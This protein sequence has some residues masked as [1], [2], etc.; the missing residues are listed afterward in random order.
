[1]K[2]AVAVEGYDES[3]FSKYGK[4]L[5][6]AVKGQRKAWDALS[7]SCSSIQNDETIKHLQKTALLDR[8]LYR[9]NRMA[10]VLLWSLL[11]PSRF[12]K[13]SGK[14]NSWGIP[15]LEMEVDHVGIFRLLSSGEI[16]YEGGETRVSYRYADLL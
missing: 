2:G 8:L 4:F 13:Q 14:F 1:V 9:D 11:E 16:Y 5:R 6:D 15:C 7:K 10:F 3:E 12:D